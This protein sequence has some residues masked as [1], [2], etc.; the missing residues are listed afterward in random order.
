MREAGSVTTRR[1]ARRVPRH[2]ALRANQ[3]DYRHRSKISPMWL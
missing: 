3:S 1:V 2:Y